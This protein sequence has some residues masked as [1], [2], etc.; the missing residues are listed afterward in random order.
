MPRDALQDAAAIELYNRHWRY[1]KELRLWLMKDQ[2]SEQSKTPTFERGTYIFFDPSTWEK[3]KKDFIVMYDALEERR[4]VGS[5]LP[6]GSTTANT[7]PL[8]SSLANGAG[9]LSNTS[10]HAN[11]MDSSLHADLLNSLNTTPGS[12]NM[13]QTGAAS[14]IMGSSLHGPHSQAFQQRQQQPHAASIG[15]RRESEV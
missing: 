8:G 14:N 6:N 15:S 12:A 2:S 5:I 7:H 11:G 9:P 1:H 4:Q 10:A 3:V 13:K